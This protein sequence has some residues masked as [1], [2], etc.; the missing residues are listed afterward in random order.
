VKITKKQLRQI[1]EEEVNKAIDKKWIKKEGHEGNW[2]EWL[3]RLASGNPWERPEKYRVPAE[4]PHEEP[5]PEELAPTEPVF[6][7]ECEGEEHPCAG[8][9]VKQ[10]MEKGF[11]R[12]AG[13]YGPRGVVRQSQLQMAVDKC[14]AVSKE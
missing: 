1:I 8:L 3:E 6:P 4:R 9:T 2:P 13:I 7:D 10:C 11:G 14:P 5:A 12:E